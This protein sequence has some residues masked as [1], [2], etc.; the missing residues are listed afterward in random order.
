MSKYEKLLMASF[1]IIILSLRQLD[2]SLLS[3][4]TEN[5]LNEKFMYAA[6][7]SLVLFTTK[8]TSI[9]SSIIK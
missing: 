3:N 7:F 6:N 2:F 9:S 4:Q 8:Q 5:L 1:K